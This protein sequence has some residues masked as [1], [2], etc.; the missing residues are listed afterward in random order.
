MY[1]CRAVAFTEFMTSRSEDVWRV[2]SVK[3][4]KKERERD[5]VC[6]YVMEYFYLQQR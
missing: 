1:V 2:E 4:V 3:L 6:V 5:C